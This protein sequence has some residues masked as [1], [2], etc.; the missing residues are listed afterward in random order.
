MGL[1]LC[2]GEIPAR[3]RREILLSLFIPSLS[4]FMPMLLLMSKGKDADAARG[5]ADAAGGR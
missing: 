2:F 1:L 3:K 5:D 4:L